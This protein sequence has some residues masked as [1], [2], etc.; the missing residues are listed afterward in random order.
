MKKADGG[1]LNKSSAKI[2]TRK[3]SSPK[4]TNKPIEPLRSIAKELHRNAAPMVQKINCKSRNCDRIEVSCAFAWA[5]CNCV[6]M[7]ASK[8]RVISA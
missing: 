2:K 3:V 7:L 6:E 1:R 5:S 4:T 8:L